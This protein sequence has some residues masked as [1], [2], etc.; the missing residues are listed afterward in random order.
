VID[1]DGVVVADVVPEKIGAPVDLGGV[2]LVDPK[3]PVT[4]ENIPKGELVFYHPSL[5]AGVQVGG[6]V[7]HMGQGVLKAALGSVTTRVL[8]ITFLI[9]CSVIVLSFLTLGRTLRPLSRVL[10]GTR[11]ISAGDF[12]AR[13]QV[14]TRDEI[15]ELAEAFNA[16]AARTELFFRYVDKDVAERLIQDENLTRPGGQLKAVSVLFGDMRGFTSLSNQRSPSE[17]VAILNTY[18]DLFFRVVHN[19]GGVVD[20]TMGDA[21]MAFFES[22]RSIDTSHSR[23]ATAAAVTMRAAVWALRRIL[24][25]ATRDGLGLGFAPQEFGFAVA[26]GRLIVGNIGSDRHLNYTVCGPAVNLAA[27]LQEETG[28]G[29]VVLDRFS[30][31]DVEDFVVCRKMPEVQPKGFSEAQWVTPFHVVALG[32]GEWTAMRR[33]LFDLFGLRFFRTHLQILRGPAAPASQDDVTQQLDQLV[34]LARR[35]LEVENPQFLVD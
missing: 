24:Q 15:G 6:V 2:A 1:A 20:K 18:Y 34:G 27:R 19:H 13:L 17:I 26:T 11:K 3:N 12:S 28:R 35:I 14:R 33:Q 4:L 32:Q 31:M 7:V 21:I 23:R 22:A 25:E 9:A 10:E 30:A 8:T 29:E 5:F 16:M